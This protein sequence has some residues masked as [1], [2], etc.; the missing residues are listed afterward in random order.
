MRLFFFRNAFASALPLA[1]CCAGLAASSS[2]RASPQALTPQSLAGDWEY[3]VN[4]PFKLILHLSTDASGALS[5]AIDTPDSPPKH[6]VLSNVR[7]V[8]NILTYTMPPLGTITEI[9]QPDGQKIVGSYIWE[10]VN[11]AAISP[12]DVAGDWQASLAGP[13]MLTLRLRLDASGSLTGT[14][15]LPM[16]KPGREKLSNIQIEGRKISFTRPDGSVLGGIFSNDRQSIAGNL[17]WQRVRTL[18]Q[19]L[20]EDAKYKPSPTDGTW[21]GTVQHIPWS[22][23]VKP[24]FDTFQFTFRFNSA[25][26]TCSVDGSIQRGRGPIPCELKLEGNKVHVTALLERV[27]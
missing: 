12:H 27:S 16:P 21:T 25:P 8:G 9:V 5:G 10:R 17:M 23:N 22:G 3:A 7:L 14:L 20:A 13:L 18:P 11:T 19:A 1:L 4:G 15:D 6:I 24:D 26:V 2:V